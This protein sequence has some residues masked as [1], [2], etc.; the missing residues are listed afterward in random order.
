MP[1]VTN[2][3]ERP[4][5][6]DL[7]VRGVVA[8]AEVLG[9]EVRQDLAGKLGGRA[10][11]HILKGEPHTRSRGNRLERR[12]DLAQAGQSGGHLLGD[13]IERSRVGHDGTGTEIG[14]RLSR[15]RERLDAVWLIG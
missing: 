11:E 7:V 3:I 4:W 15:R 8:E 14:C 13:E 6:A 12:A 5:P 10:W 9:I 2:Q 1:Q